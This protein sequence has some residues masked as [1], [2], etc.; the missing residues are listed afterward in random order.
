MLEKLGYRPLLAKNGSEAV[1]IVET[2]DGDIDVA[3]LDLKLPDMDGGIVYH[4]I[5]EN[6]PNLKVIICSGYAIDG[7][8]QEILDAGAEGFI[9]KPFT[10]NNFSVIIKDILLG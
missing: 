2:F 3:L 5:M 10:L 8:A 1:N 6:R 9:Q 7:P 4:R